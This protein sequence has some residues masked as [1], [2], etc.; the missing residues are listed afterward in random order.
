MMR[1]SAFRFLWSALCV[2][3][4]DATILCSNLPDAINTMQLGV[5]LTTIDLFSQKPA[6]SPLPTLKLTCNNNITWI[7]S[8]NGIQYNLPDQL[9][10]APIAIPTSVSVTTN[11]QT[12]N[13]KGLHLWM[14]ETIETD[15]F[16]G[17]ASKTKTISQSY[18]AM[19]VENRLWGNVNSSTS[20]F[21]INFLP[22][23]IAPNLIQLS[24]D[25]QNYISDTIQTQ[26][27]IFNESTIDLYETFF[28]YFGTH[29]FTAA[30]TAGV[31]QERYES[32]K[33]LLYEMNSQSIEAN[34]AADFFNFLLKSGAVSGEKKTVNEKFVSMSMIE[35]ICFGGTF[36][37]TSSADYDKWQISVASLPW[38]VSA[39]FIPVH[40]LM[41]DG[42]QIQSSFKAS[43]FNHQ[44]VAFLQHEI[45]G[46]IDKLETILNHS[47][48]ITSTDQM[49][50]NCQLPQ[51]AQQCVIDHCPDGQQSSLC[52]GK[53]AL[54]NCAAKY[55]VEAEHS[56]HSW[57]NSTVGL[58]AY[59]NELQGVQR[60][61]Q[62]EINLVRNNTRFLLQKS[63]VY[64]QELFNQTA[65]LFRSLTESL[66]TN[67]IWDW[68]GFRTKVSCCVNYNNYNKCIVYGCS[69][70]SD[71]CTCKGCGGK[72]L[73]LRYNLTYL[74]GLHAYL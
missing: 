47:I 26:G 40:E 60:K 23:K 55:V 62:N 46:N 37:P 72:C 20:A 43:I 71:A 14:S 39:H 27:P 3:Y 17:L 41:T 25:A 34:G 52:G 45:M 67:Y 58:Q 28:E 33:Y 74:A 50:A 69:G 8:I 15:Y 7:N 66:E 49:A 4:I 68:C 56:F 16:F 44:Q 61:L 19:T 10:E 29:A 18:T 21:Q 32:D 2:W 65:V 30:F 35:Q 5:D 12:L 42:S 36:C 24:D 64:D 9:A 31:F 38:I 73:M 6:W 51:A 59:L 1:L 48:K 11:F 57:V 22:R 53:C 70:E 54:N 63:I 13:V